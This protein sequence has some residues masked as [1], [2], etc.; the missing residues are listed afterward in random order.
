ML[1]AVQNAG[2]QVMGLP[3]LRSAS[4]RLSQDCVRHNEVNASIGTFNERVMYSYKT[5]VYWPAT[6]VLRSCERQRN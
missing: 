1:G 2:L 4:K 3:P 6:K 5:D